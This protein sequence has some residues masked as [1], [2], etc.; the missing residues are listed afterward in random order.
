MSSSRGLSLYEHIV[1]CSW[2][3]DKKKRRQWTVGGGNSFVRWFVNSH[4]AI[5]NRI[6]KIRIII[7]ICA[8]HNIYSNNMIFPVNPNY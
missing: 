7:D 5:I 6:C 1:Q 2:I 4:D 8:M 3:V